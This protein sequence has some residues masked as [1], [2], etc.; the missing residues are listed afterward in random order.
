[1]IVMDVLKWIGTAGAVVLLLLAIEFVYFVAVLA[2]S[3]ERTRGLGYYGLPP[4]GRARYKAVLRLHAHLLRPV[5]W[6]THRLST[7]SYEKASIRHRDVTGPK[8]T[9]TA[10]SFALGMS[11]E[12]QVDD[13]FV[14]TQMKCGT[15]WMQHVVYEVL[16]RGGGDLAESGRTLYGVSPWLEAVT[17]VPVEQAPLH[18]RERPARI[19]KTHFPASVCPFSTSSRYIYVARHPASCFASCVDFIGTNM[20]IMAPP[21]EVTEQWF[22]SEQMWWTPWTDHLSGWWQRSRAEA[23]VLFVRFEDMKHDLEAVVIRVTAF[24][25]LRPLGREEL[26]EVVRKCSFGYMQENRETFEMNPPHLLQTDAELFVRGSVQRHQ[27][28]PEE[29]R[30]RILAWC[31]NELEENDVDLEQIYPEVA[32]TRSPMAPEVPN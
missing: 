13:V 25:G 2:W 24:L 28:V 17:S 23:N 8:G 31:V 11:Y 14:V 22:C 16:M 18:G 6:L 15:T 9:C 29:V 21:L 3:A 1:V 20:G 7:F 5:L 32:A 10:D 30:D 19:I 26:R 12:P 4:E 27:D